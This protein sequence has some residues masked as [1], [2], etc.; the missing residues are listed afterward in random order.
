MV[1]DDA[2]LRAVALGADGIVAGLKPGAVYG[3]MSTASP[4]LTCEIGEAVAARGATMLDAPVSGSTITVEQGQ[5]SIMVGGD[6]RALDRVRP[7]LATMGPGG[8]THVGPLGLAK[9]MKIAMNLTLP[10]Q[11]LAFSE[12][13]LLA[14]KSG[15]ARETAVEAILKSVAASPMVKYRGPFVLGRMPQEAWFNVAKIQKDLRLALELGRVKGVPLPSVALA[16]E[17]LSAAQGMGL[18]EY[19]FAVV[20]DVLARMSG[21]PG[22][23]KPTGGA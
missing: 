20:F 1:M 11:L 12:A 23:P 5:A 10:V 19:D 4:A 6:A 9:A 18:G 17:M 8:I 7:Y 22:S 13:V 14:E 15:I 16:H 21:L 2:A 3:E